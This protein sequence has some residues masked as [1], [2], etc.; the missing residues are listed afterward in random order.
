MEPPAPGWVAGEG[1]VDGNPED[2][3]TVT[4][5]AAVATHMAPLR[6]LEKGTHVAP[7]KVKQN[8]HMTQRFHS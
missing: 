8:C 7:Q 6:A 5:S 4:G 2:C 3:V 1:W